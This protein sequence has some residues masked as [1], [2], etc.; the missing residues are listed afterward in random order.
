MS[1]KHK[2]DID[3]Q[4]GYK[5]EGGEWNGKCNKEYYEQA[6]GILETGRFELIATVL[7]VIDELI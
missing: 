4:D 7:Y 6:K 1:W 5:Y 2:K 3:V